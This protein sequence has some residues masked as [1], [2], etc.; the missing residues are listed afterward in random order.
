MLHKISKR[1]R[2]SQVVHSVAQLVWGCRSDERVN[3]NNRILILLYHGLKYAIVI[4][5]KCVT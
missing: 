1:M 5:P 4:G 2:Q 3:I